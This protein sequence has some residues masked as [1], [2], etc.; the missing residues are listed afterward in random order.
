M[1]DEVSV[2]I[3]FP[4]ELRLDADARLYVRLE[5]ISYADA[6]AQI[7]AER[8]LRPVQLPATGVLEVTL[9]VPPE[10]IVAEGRYSVRVHLDIDADE[11]VSVGDWISV[12]THPVL[13]GGHPASVRVTPTRVQ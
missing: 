13:T 5:D 7:V 4:A 11:T 8:S 1:D 10:R 6:P 9:R 12:Q 3:T 2:T